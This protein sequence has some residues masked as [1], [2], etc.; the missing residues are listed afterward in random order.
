MKTIEKCH[1]KNDNGTLCL[2]D[3]TP[4]GQFFGQ[5]PEYRC[6]KGHTKLNNSIGIECD[7]CKDNH[8]QKK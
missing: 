8:G 1:H 3:E 4:T 2:A 5:M 6:T 7:S